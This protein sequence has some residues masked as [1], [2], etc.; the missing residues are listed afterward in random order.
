MRK[1][2]TLVTVLLI[3]PYTSAESWVVLEEISVSSFSPI[4]PP[5]LLS[6]ENGSNLSDITPSLAWENLAPIDN[7]HVQLDESED[8]SSPL[9][10]FTPSCSLELPPLQEG[11]YFWR[12]RAFRSG[13][14]SDWS[15]VFSFRVDVSPPSSPYLLYPADGENFVNSVPLLAWQSPAENS[16]P[17]LF[18]V[19]LD[20]SHD[21]PH[22]VSV[23]VYGENWLPPSLGQDN[24]YWRVKARDNAGNEGDWSETRRFEVFDTI[25]PSPPLPLFPLAYENLNDNTPVFRWNAPDENSLPLTYCVQVSPDRYQIFT[26]AW[27]DNENWECSSVLSDGLWY[28]RVCARDRA[29]NTGLFSDWIPFIVDT[30]NPI[31]PPLLSP[32]EGAEFDGTSVTFEWGEG[33]DERT[34]VSGY[35]IQFS[36]DSSF[37]LPEAEYFL[38]GYQFF[39][40]FPSLGDWYWR[41]GSVDGAGNVGWSEIRRLVCR[42]WRILESQSFE[43]SGFA[44][45]KLLD[46]FIG[47]AEGLVGQWQEIE[48]MFSRS[49]ALPQ[50]TVVQLWD[51]GAR[52]KADWKIGDQMTVK[53]YSLIPVPIPLLPENSAHVSKVRLCWENLKA[54]DNFEIQ[55]D[56]PSKFWRPFRFTYRT[57]YSKEN[58]FD[59]PLENLQD[60][61]YLWRVRAWRSG[62]CSPWS[63]IFTFVLDRQVSTPILLLPDNGC[64]SGIKMVTFSWSEVED[65]TPPVEY[66]VQVSTSPD[67]SSYVSSGWLSWRIWE[68]ELEEGFYFWR[69]RARDN[70]GNIGEFSPARD[71][72]ID[73]TPPTAPRLLYPSKGSWITSTSV[74]LSW[75]EVKDDSLPVVYVVLVDD[76][77]DFFS[78]RIVVQTTTSSIVVNVTDGTWHWQVMAIDNAGNRSLPST[79]FFNVDATPPS[80]PAQI[81]PAATLLTSGKVTFTWSSVEDPNGVYYDLKIEGVLEKENLREN[82]FQVVLSPGRYTWRI[83][84]KDGLGNTRGWSASSA[85][86]I[87]DVKP[88]LLKLLE[89]LTKTVEEDFIL[90]V[91]I[92]DDFGIDEN[93][94]QVRVDGQEIGFMLSGDLLLCELKGIPQGRHLVEILVNDVGS[95]E[96]VLTWDL[97]VLPRV[98]TEISTREEKGKIFVNLHAKNRSELP[99]TKRYMLV[100]GGESKKLEVSLNPGEETSM[101]IE[102][103]RANANALELIDLGTGAK[104]FLPLRQERGFPYLLLLPVVSSAVFGL[105][106]LLRRPR[107]VP[108]EMSTEEEEKFPLPLPPP[109]KEHDDYSLLSSLFRPELQVPFTKEWSR[110]RKRYSTELSPLME[111]YARLIREGPA[112]RLIERYREMMRGR[113]S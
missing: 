85:F 20:N 19:Q 83:R 71:F 28:W 78:P 17:L 55:I 54:A 9:D 8:F 25:P 72:R 68:V 91:K 69:V 36:R 103:S 43:I 6:P 47:F 44:R 94:I 70:L 1:L 105:G 89:P 109:Q 63:E 95:N 88:P 29:G 86:E 112:P 90:R 57:W 45:W 102:V 38:S 96:N 92:I 46:G 84:A 73:L 56:V 30:V 49:E 61:S 77:A 107:V 27:T 7:F 3:T 33:T 108:P 42:G 104:T 31:P 23:W 34:G 106:V 65:T 81:Q 13:L 60:G 39:Y 93:R 35:V 14:A 87:R 22:P 82:F 12:V 110:L 59:L 24:Y 52:G 74:T 67:F 40:S 101:V 48:I 53:L 10:F 76:A 75:E 64:N 5:I 80:M 21:F 4:P 111:E 16:L 2:F 32:Q 100:L 51:L 41:V 98:I 79:A 58:F 62:A 18:L 37:S 113:A 11:I 50:W 26:S 99:V 66:E 97:L 15:I